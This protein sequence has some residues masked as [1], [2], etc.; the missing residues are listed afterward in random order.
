MV[1]GESHDQ[2]VDNWSLGILAYELL[3]GKPP[4]EHQSKKKFVV[5]VVVCLFQVVGYFFFF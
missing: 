4:F 3:V 1:S 2:A 5:V